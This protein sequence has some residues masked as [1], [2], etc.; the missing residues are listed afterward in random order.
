MTFKYLKYTVTALYPPFAF[1]IKAYLLAAVVYY[2]HTVGRQVAA[3]V[4]SNIYASVN[5]AVTERLYLR[6][7]I[8][9]QFCY[10]IVPAFFTTPVS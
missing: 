10:S 2:S 4:F 8:G 5:D 7:F 9:G 6:K 1:G 3:V